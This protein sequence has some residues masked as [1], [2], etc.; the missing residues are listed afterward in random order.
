MKC[1]LHGLGDVLREWASVKHACAVLGHAFKGLRIGRVFQEVAFWQGGVAIKKV[2]FG[3]GG[4]GHALGVFCAGLGEAGGNGK[5]V[6]SQGFGR[7][8]EISPLLFAPAFVSGFHQ[9]G[10]AGRANGP[11]PDYS[12]EEFQGFAL[13]V[14]EQGRRGSERGRFAPV[15]G[16]GFACF[17]IVPDQK[18]PPSETGGLGFDKAKDRLNGD[19][20]IGGC[21]A[22][23]QDG[24]P[25]LCGVGICS[26]DHPV[27]RRDR[28]PRVARGKGCARI[29][30]L[31]SKGCCAECEQCGET[32]QEGHGQAFRL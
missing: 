25:C 32:G 12:V 15:K 29:G 24:G 26:G 16:G 30:R 18:C 5:A 20:R 6:F 19:H 21:A 7:G 17:C 22:L 27:L 14:L 13:G 23:A 2:G 8:E 28:L 3:G 1:G 10:G 11:A 4:G 9:G 31:G